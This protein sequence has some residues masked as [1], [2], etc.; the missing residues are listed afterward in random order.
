MTMSRE[1]FMRAARK[2]L[3]AAEA[4]EFNHD[5][6][7]SSVT[8]Q[9]VIDQDLYTVD[10]RTGE[11]TNGPDGR[12]DPN[13]ETGE[14]EE[15]GIMFL[16]VNLTAEKN[17]RG[18]PTKV[19]LDTIYEISENDIDDMGFETPESL[20]EFIMNGTRAGLAASE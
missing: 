6:V 8:T 7:F 13:S 17:E 12:W 5:V 19:H 15:P 1:D 16:R 14:G 3:H 4:N 18:F 20:A 10:P 9:A 11:I 2:I